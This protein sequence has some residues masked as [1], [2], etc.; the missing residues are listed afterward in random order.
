MVGEG[1]PGAGVS[2]TPPAFQPSMGASSQRDSVASSGR[3][4]AE[5]EGEERPG[6]GFGDEGFKV[7]DLGFKIGWGLVDVGVRWVGAGLVQLR[8]GAVGSRVRRSSIRNM[9]ACPAVMWQGVRDVVETRHLPASPSQNKKVDSPGGGI[10]TWIVCLLIS[11]SQQAK[12][13]GTQC[14]MHSKENLVMF[15]PARNQ[16]WIWFIE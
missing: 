2:T 1:E 5:G 13:V 8:E 7:W 3:V 15:G 10:F 14:G 16:T 4:C 11:H 9:A 6:L 12:P